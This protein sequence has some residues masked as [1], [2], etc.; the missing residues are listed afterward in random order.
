MSLRFAVV[1]E[2]EADFRTATELADRVLV[3]S[4][5][6]LD[7]ILEHQREWVE[8]Q[9]KG[10]RLTWKGVKKLADDI[11][12]GFKARGHFDGR[13]GDADAAAARRAILSIKATFPDVKAILLI[14]DQD[15]QPGRK[16]GLEQARGQDHGETVVV[17]GL[18][19]VEREAWVVCGFH[20]DNPDE[21]S[22]HAE[23]RQTLGFDPCERSHELTAGKDDRAAKS[24][25]RVLLQLC[26]GDWD[27]QRRCWMN[28]PLD[29]L[30][31][32]GGGNGLA[33]YLGEVR[34]RL[35]S[36]LGPVPR[37]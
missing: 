16:V 12:L 19:V 10:Q 6:W 2:A 7:G 34:D 27:R 32:R 30:R 26:G 37:S 22:R 14:R 15:D 18:A 25:K 4:H 20:P 21:T 33:A 24:P 35:A 8:R 13:P 29:R 23:E 1:H 28:T 11:G 36:L 5:G 9:P 31:E 17:V 3:E